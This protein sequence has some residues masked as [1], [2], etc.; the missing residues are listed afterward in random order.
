[1][2]AGLYGSELV[3]T[4]PT[5]DVREGGAVEPVTQ[6]MTPGKVRER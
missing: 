3:V 6:E 1:M 4:G 2:T 5:D